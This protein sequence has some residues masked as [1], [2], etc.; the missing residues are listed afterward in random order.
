MKFFSNRVIQNYKKLASL[1]ESNAK[2]RYVQLCRSLKTWGI[3]FFLVK[4][5]LKGGHAKKPLKSYLGVTREGLVFMDY[6]TKEITKEY[7]LEHLLRWAASPASFTLDWGD[8]EADYTILE[9]EEGE[10]ISQLIGGYIDI[11]LKKRSDVGSISSED[12]SSLA[13]EEPV[14][15]IR[16]QALMSSSLASI[17]SFQNFGGM[18]AIYGPAGQLMSRSAM[19]VSPQRAVP[20]N[21]GSAATFISAVMQDLDNVKKK[22]K[23]ST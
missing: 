19:A 15:P 9:T 3:T 2:Y 1:S 20:T 11:L 22:K 5:R 8:H 21:L 6:E 7:P 14:A 13:L 4:Q 16:S 18:E 23:I 17:G 12:S 10:A